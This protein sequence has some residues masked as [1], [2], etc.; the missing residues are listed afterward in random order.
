MRAPK[1]GLLTW[2][3]LLNNS[4]DE[5]IDLWRPEQPTTAHGPQA[6]QYLVLL[7]HLTELISK[8]SRIQPQ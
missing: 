3:A 6:V 7:I 2:A 4:H 8:P 5:E 1:P